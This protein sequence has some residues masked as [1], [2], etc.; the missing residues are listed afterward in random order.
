M[1]RRALLAL[2]AGLA[3]LALVALRAARSGAPAATL[4]RPAF[5][6]ALSA[7]APATPPGPSAAG[8][9]AT[10]LATPPAPSAARAPAPAPTPAT[11]APTAATARIALAALD[12]VRAAAYADP[13]SAD[14][15]AWALPSCAC[16]AE[17][18]HRLRDLARSGLA[19]RGHA[20]TL[21]SLAVLAARAGP[22]PR[23]EA[24]V[25]DRVGAYT[26][27]DA[28]GRVVR[29]W[30]ASAPRRW[31]ITLVRTAGRWRYAAVARAP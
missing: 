23:V 21:T 20:V 16:H 17:D 14:P 4:A 5:P 24:L 7:L 1:S 12:R 27:V 29:R 11:P 8:A 15:G 28:A 10:P 3:V 9:P 26:A 25:T 30:P 6:A 31:R 19:L 22:A 2:V 18:A 13:R